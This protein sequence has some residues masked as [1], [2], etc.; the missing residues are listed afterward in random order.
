MAKRVDFLETID[1]GGQRVVLTVTIVNG[2]LAVVAGDR[3]LANAAEMIDL[4]R[5]LPGYEDVT[6]ENGDRFLEA[7]HLAYSGSRIRATRPYESPGG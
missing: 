7:L 6:L 3:R 5:R 2:Q 4:V 1:G